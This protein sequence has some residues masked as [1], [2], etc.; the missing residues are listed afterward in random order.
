MSEE[1]KETSFAIVIT[2][3]FDDKGK[4]DGMVGC[5]MEEEVNHDLTEDQLMQIRSVCGIMA[6]T[7]S[8]MEQDQEFFEYVRE[9][10]FS[11]NEDLIFK[12]VDA[13]EEK[14][15]KPNFT[16]EGNVFTLNF[17]SKTHGNA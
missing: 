2:P 12:F 11:L 14:D 16:K 13:I 6:N 1:K 10:F 17:N 3:E 8:L 15:E 9:A 5:H 7:I 4:W